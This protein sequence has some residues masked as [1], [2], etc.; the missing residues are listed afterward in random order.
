MGKGLDR[1]EQEDRACSHTVFGH[2]KVP[3]QNSTPNPK[4]QTL[5][6]RILE[7]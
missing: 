4:P 2:E 5:K 3:K 6:I 7:P 1:A